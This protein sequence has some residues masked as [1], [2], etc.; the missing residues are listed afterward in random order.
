MNMRPHSIPLPGTIRAAARV[1][2]REALTDALQGL[3]GW[4]TTDRKVVAK[5][6]APGGE[7]KPGEHESVSEDVAR[8]LSRHRLRPGDLVVGRKGD[9]GRAALVGDRED[10]WVAAA[11]RSRS[12]CA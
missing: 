1:A 9:L 5:T 11:T 8:R 7:I 3:T 12:E 6:I 2:E 4:S 10:G